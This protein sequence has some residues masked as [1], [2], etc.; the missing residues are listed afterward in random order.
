MSNPVDHPPHYYFYLQSTF[1]CAMH[2]TM[3]EHSIDETLSQFRHVRDMVMRRRRFHGYSGKARMACG[4]LALAGA[5]VL[6]SSRVP[7]TAQAHLAGWGVVL[8]LALVIN[9]GAVAWWFVSH[10]DVR[11]EPALLKPALDAVPALAGGAVLTIALIAARQYDLLFGAW[12]LLYGL[13]QTTYRNALPR[14]VFFTGL[15]YMGCGSLLLLL[16]QSFT[17]PLPMGGV[18]FLGEL[19]GGVCLLKPEDDLL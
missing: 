16:P 13:A 6:A 5:L 11:S 19:V 18:F 7:A 10:P 1:S 9:Y 8:A 12:M 15:M 4:M 17:N 14:G 2:N 3:N